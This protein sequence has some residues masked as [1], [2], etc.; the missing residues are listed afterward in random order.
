M[1]SYKHIVALNYDLQ[2]YSSMASDFQ[3]YEGVCEIFDVS[4]DSA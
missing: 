1:N 4:L 2:D 3:S